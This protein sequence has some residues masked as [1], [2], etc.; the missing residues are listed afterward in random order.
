MTG[1]LINHSIIVNFSFYLIMRSFLIHILFEPDQLESMIKLD[2]VLEEK[3]I[4]SFL[5]A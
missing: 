1:H 4:H 3:K 5:T 2:P